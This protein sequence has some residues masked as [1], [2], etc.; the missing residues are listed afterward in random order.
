MDY[1]Q[2]PNPISNW[3]EEDRPREKMLHIGRQN[4]SNAELIAILLGSGS[5]NKSAVD[6]SKEILQANN[7][8][9]YELG[10]CSVADL[11]KFNGMG[12]AKAITLLAAME[13]GRRRKAETIQKKP[14]IKSAK[15]AHQVLAPYLTDLPHEEFW[16]LCL[17][18]ANHVTKALRISEG[19]MTGTV[20][21]PKKIFL[22]ALEMQAASIII[23]HNHPSGNT[24][25]SEADL[26]I[27][28][29]IKEGGQLLDLPI[30]D[31]LIITDHTY[32]SFA[33]EG[34]L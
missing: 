34:L 30:L 5:R 10:K 20:A 31:H 24:T 2:T 13:L 12:P 32:L 28:K 7:N 33:D 15:D 21:D 29:K 16:L 17:N 27:T 11:T 6:L 19:G 1:P 25:P 3:A 4:L 23:A 26:K 8:S 18:R 9:L 14:V 22:K